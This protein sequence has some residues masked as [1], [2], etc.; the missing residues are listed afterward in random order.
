MDQLQEDL[1][2]PEHTV[3][4]IDQ[5]DRVT[6]NKTLTF[7]KVKWSNHTE[8]ESTWE[9]KEFLNSKF[10]EFLASQ[11]RYAPSSSFRSLHFQIS[12]RDFL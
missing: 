4:I 9:T 12:G 10:P 11:L 3:R 2:Y 6:W 5:K 8:D 7:N 1:S